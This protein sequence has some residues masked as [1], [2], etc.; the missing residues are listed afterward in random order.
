MDAVPETI[1][2]YGAGKDPYRSLCWQFTAEFGYRFVGTC[3]AWAGACAEK[4]E[5]LYP[6]ACEEERP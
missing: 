1:R 2:T 4:L 6:A 3:E 5:E